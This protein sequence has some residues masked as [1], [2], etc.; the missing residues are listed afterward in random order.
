[1]TGRPMMPRRARVI[2]L[3]V[4]AGGVGGCSPDIFD[5]SVQ[6]GAEAFHLDFGNATGNVPTVA[7]DAA[8]PQVCG[9]GQTIALA[10]GAGET[11]VAVG[12]DAGSARCFVKADTRVFYV[13]DVLKDDAFTS[14][15]GRRAVSLVRMLDV[16]Y[17]VPVNTATFAIPQIDVY[18]GPGQARVSGDPGVVAVDSVPSIAPAQV[19]TPDAPGHL[20]IADGSPA[21]TLIED[22]IK[23]KT[24]FTFIVQ[25]SPRLE[26]GSPLP[27]GR[28]DLSLQPLLALGLR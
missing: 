27:A 2:A 20:T 24:P 26:S 18:V 13:V 1:M 23:R 22:S 3:A 25:V 6:L 28:M 19:I 12:C 8:N 5:V 9:N 15:V 14:K 7:C 17:A 11:E 16:A 21:R 4:V 10:D